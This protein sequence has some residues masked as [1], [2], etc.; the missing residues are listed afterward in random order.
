MNIALVIDF[1]GTVTDEDVGV[2]ILDTFSLE[3]WRVYE[4]L[5]LSGEISLRDCLAGEYTTLPSDEPRLTQYAVSETEIRDGFRE[6][7]D[8]CNSHEWPTLIVSGGLDFYIR[9]ILNKNGLTS[10]EFVSGHAVFSGGDRLSIRW[11]KEP[12]SCLRNGT[13]KCY[14]VSKMAAAGY[15]VVFI[16]DGI[17]DTCVADKADYVFARHR[18]ASY[19]E[20]NNIAFHY[21]NTFYEIQD[22]LSHIING[23]SH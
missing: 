15:Q 23:T 9:A 7:V 1:D 22:T 14:Y 12:F 2:G 19:C 17:T 13:C 18:L 3:D 21:F 10:Q 16:G 5:Y 4:K 11:D 20:D 6:F 8:Y